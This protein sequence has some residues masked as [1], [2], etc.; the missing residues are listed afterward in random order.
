[1]STRKDYYIFSG[2]STLGDHY[3]EGKLFAQT[4]TAGSSY[5]LDHIIL[6]LIRTG[7]TGDLTVTIVATTSGLPTGAPISTGTVV[8]SGVPTSLGLV[9][10]AMSG[11]S[12]VAGTK[13]A[14]CMNYPNHALGTHIEWNII[15]PGTYPGGSYCLYSSGSWVAYTAYDFYFDT[16]DGT[17]VGKA[18]NPTPADDATEVPLYLATLSWGAATGAVSYNV[19][20]SW[21][22]SVSTF[23]TIGTSWDLSAVTPLYMDRLKH[24]TEYFWRVDTVGEEETVTGDTWS[25]TV[26]PL[27]YP[28]C[29]YT[30]LP[31]MTL[32]PLDGGVEGID[33]IWNG[34]NNMRTSRWLIAAARN[35]IWYEDDT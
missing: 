30:I 34:S 32:G 26:L 28:V 31:G 14:I 16:Y 29:S 13:Y 25:F 6:K 9:T 22:G 11:V 3:G 10:I 20:C 5:T 18:T 21:S 24:G 33:F 7:S 23:S 27:R 12:I 2:T 1:V 35:R 19:V 4:F 8:E 17:A 15:T